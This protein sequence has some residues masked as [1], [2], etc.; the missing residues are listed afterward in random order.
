MFVI[1]TKSVDWKVFVRSVLRVDIR[2]PSIPSGADY[3]N[4][5]TGV[6]ASEQVGEDDN[7]Q[8]TNRTVLVTLSL[9]AD[10]S[11]Q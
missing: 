11:K 6:R 2:Q 3:A 8:M 5:T 7:K 1:D 9:T 10:S 4:I